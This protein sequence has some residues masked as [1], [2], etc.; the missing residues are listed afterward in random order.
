M[1]ARQIL[2]L[3]AVLM[4]LA[5]LVKELRG[6]A[7]A[8]ATGKLEAATHEAQD[9]YFTLGTLSIAVP[10]ESVAA[11]TLRQYLGKDV[12]LVVIENEPRKLQQVER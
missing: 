5:A 7:Y 12:R 11:V 1:I 9:G 4:F 3:V 10:K 6:D 2:M 8:L